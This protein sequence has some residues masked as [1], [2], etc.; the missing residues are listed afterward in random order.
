VANIT[1]KVQEKLDSLNLAP[2]QKKYIG[3]NVDQYPSLNKKYLKN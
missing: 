1:I 2:K 3:Y